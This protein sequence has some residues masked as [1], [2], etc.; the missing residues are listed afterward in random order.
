MKKVFIITFLLSSILTFQINASAKYH[1]KTIKSSDGTPIFFEYAG[2]GDTA[3]VFVHGWNC[4]VS[5]WYNQMEFFKNKYRVV[6]LDLAGHGYSGI[7]RINYTI[8]AFGEDVKAVVEDQNLNKVI[9]V[10]H[11]M[12]GAVIIEAS[13]LLGERV[14][15]LIG[16]DTFQDWSAEYTEEQKQQFI[17]PLKNDFKN[18]CPQFVTGMFPA[19]ADKELVDSV[20][21]SMCDADYVVSMSSIENLIN[22][23]PASS[24]SQ[25]NCPIVS[26]NSTFFPTNEEGNRMLA[27][28]FEVKYMEGVGH[29]VMLEDPD[30][31]NTILSET[32][33]ELL[34]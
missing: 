21:I 25:I 24:L 18:A 5:F 16:A 12:G 31:F 19:D 13:I 30:R 27:K 7:Q 9:L 22:Y 4:D 33:R 29:F 6:A 28:S 32:V 3:L 14:A 11:S 23:N 20:I 17:S 34:N 15:G 1:S 8:E 26:I 10:G 2:D